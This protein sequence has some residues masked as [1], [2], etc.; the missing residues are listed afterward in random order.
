MEIKQEEKARAK[1]EKQKIKAHKSF[2]RK[3]YKRDLLKKKKKK[4][5]G[6]LQKLSFNE[7]IYM[8]VLLLL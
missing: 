6:E 3:K 5:R 7:L 1:E 2:L 4:E 8:L